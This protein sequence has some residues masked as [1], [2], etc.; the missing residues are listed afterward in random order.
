MSVPFLVCC[1]SLL[2]MGV[3]KAKHLQFLSGVTPTSYWF[4]TFCWDFTNYLVPALV[5]LIVFS[6]YQ[7][8]AYTNDLGAVFL[9]LVQF[10]H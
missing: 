3:C 7:I 6:A 2:M 9:V 5:I 1:C 10:P 8:D 4:G